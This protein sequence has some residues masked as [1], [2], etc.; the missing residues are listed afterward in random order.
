MNK[1]R[2]ALL[3]EL[4]SR[5]F[6]EYCKLKAQNFYKEDRTYL[7]DMTNAMQDFCENDDDALIINLPPRH[8]KS[9]TASLLVQWL[10]GNNNSCKVMTASYNETLSTVFS[11]QVRDNIMEEK[12]DDDKIVY[13]DIF[14]NV[15]IK[16]GDAAAKMW[17]LEGQSVNNYLATSPSGTATGFG[18]DFII[19]DDLI[20]SAYEAN[21]Q[22]ILENHWEW[23][24]NTM[25]SRL[26]GKRKIIIIMTRW[27][28]NDLAGKALEFFK[29]AGM[30]V[31]NISMKAFDGNKM[32]CEEILNKNQYNIL[33]QTL[34]EEIASANYNQVPL[35]LR[36][37][38]YNVFPTYTKLPDAFESVYNYTDTADE[39]SDYLCSITAGLYNNKLYVL[40]IYYTQDPMEITE[41]ELA[42]RLCE[43]KVNYCFIES[44]N[45]GRGFGRN[46]K[47]LALEKGNK[48]TVFDMFTQ[49]KN[50]KSR[51]LSEATNVM[52]C[53]IYPEF[54]KQKYHKFCID[55]KN[56]QRAGK[57]LHDDAPDALTG[58]IEKTNLNNATTWGW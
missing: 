37:A 27:S 40:D 11:K 43:Y 32:L 6:W 46:V 57:N 33:M 29:D 5:D 31:K 30:K 48:Y 8:G 20:K 42:K 4:A 10:L 38:L 41:P 7:K 28:T 13:S 56:Y 58:L 14:P 1:L 49:T 53:I 34:G 44:N 25:M 9:R 51:I 24:T 15:R 45:G 35:N 18:A 19:V 12:S 26:Q 36:G 39:G 17:S 16:K 22:T 50:K 23:F 55:I 54:W 21:N 47:R 3:C 52:N 2:K